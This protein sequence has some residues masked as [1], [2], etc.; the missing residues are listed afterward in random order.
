MKPLRSDEIFGNWATTLLH[1]NDDESI[2]FKSLE[3]DLRYIASCGVNGI[4][5]NGTAGEFNEQT[6]AEFKKISELTAEICAEANVPFQ[7]GASHT[8]VRT[9]LDRISFAASLRPGAIQ[10]ILP[11]WFPPNDD[12]AIDFLKK[13][14]ESA[15]GIGLVIYNPPHAKRV[16]APKEFGYFKSAV[17][18]IVGIKVKSGD[19]SWFEDMREHCG[20]ISVFIPGHFLSTGLAN[21]ASG[22]YSN[23]ACLH[24]L[25]AQKWFEMMQTSPDDALELE[26]R[27]QN[28]IKEYILPFRENEG[29]SNAALDKLLAAVG[30]WGNAGTKLRFPYRGV[31]TARLPLLREAAKREIREIVLP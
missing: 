8:S 23:V 15:D 1:I 18:A 5:T 26:N 11:D 13:C 31:E 7:I 27:I 25:G 17:D 12:E 28:Y 10:I 21:G 14:A 2:C 20:D 9:M 6:E 29:Y 16:L 4:Y 24:P 30:D 3:A 19:E 22:S